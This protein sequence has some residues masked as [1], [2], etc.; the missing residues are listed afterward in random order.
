M[1]EIIEKAGSHAWVIGSTPPK[2]I[3]KHLSRRIRNHL[4]GVA[5]YRA[6]SPDFRDFLHNVW[7]SS[8]LEVAELEKSVAFDLFSAKEFRKD[9]APP[10]RQAWSENISRFVDSKVT[11]NLSTLRFNQLE[12]GK[13][14]SLILEWEP[15]GVHIKF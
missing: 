2:I 7:L 9:L 11:L 15:I 4:N 5:L 10:L 14:H 3:R 12:A 8:V 6:T 1:E 13:L